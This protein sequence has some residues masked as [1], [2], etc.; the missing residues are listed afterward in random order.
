MD[1]SFW[2]LTSFSFSLIFRAS[3]IISCS[4]NFLLLVCSL[5]GVLGFLDLAFR[6]LFL[7]KLCDFEFD[8]L[9][10]LL[11]LFL[12]FLDLD[13]GLDFDLDFLFFFL[14][15][16]LRVLDLFLLTKEYLE[17]EL[18]LGYFP[19]RLLLN[20]LRLRLLDSK[21]RESLSFFVCLFTRKSI[22]L[23]NWSIFLKFRLSNLALFFEL[24]E[25]DLDFEFLVITVSKAKDC[26]SEG[27]RL[28]LWW[29]D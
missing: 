26:I 29:L 8:F 11:L 15:F 3:C 1:Y 24:S 14:R 22:S 21:L 7:F 28:L 5:W 25:R 4:S 13:F 9:R 16:F 18:L 27:N 17:V 6:D 2:S 23:H 12:G 19:F 10:C 20:L